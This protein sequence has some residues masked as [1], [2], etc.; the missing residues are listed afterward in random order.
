MKKTKFRGIAILI[1]IVATIFFLVPNILQMVSPDTL[2]YLPEFWGNKKLKLGLDLQGGMQILLD[3]DTSQLPEK[4]KDN[5]VKS[6][7]EVIRNRID[8]FGV[9]EPSIQ[10]IGT[11]RIMVQLPGLKEINRAKDLIG[12]TALLE[13]KL[14]AEGEQVKSVMNAADVFLAKNID[15]FR[16]LQKF[17]ETDKN[18]PANTTAANILQKTAADT[19]RAAVDSLLAEDSGHIFTNLVGSGKENMSIGYEDFNLMQTLLSDSMFTAAIPTGFQISMGKEDKN[20]P[21]ADREIYVLYRP[22]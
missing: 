3:V 11:D 19:S 13:F 7:I 1:F 18:K 17:S 8:Q 14:V 12:K 20:D 21:R 6:A 15:H 22:Q 16:Y 10:R 5:A 4:E 9:A 2:K